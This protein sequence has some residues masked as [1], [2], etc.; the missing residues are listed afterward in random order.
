MNLQA[1]SFIINFTQYEMV[2]PLA[3]AVYPRFNMVTNGVQDTVT[4]V[5]TEGW[6]IRQLSHTS[7]TTFLLFSSLPT[8]LSKTRKDNHIFFSF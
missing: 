4:D 5:A 7:V 3:Q 1:V 8:V 2:R 6:G